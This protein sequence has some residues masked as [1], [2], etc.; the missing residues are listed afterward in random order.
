MNGAVNQ[1][2]VLDGLSDCSGSVVIEDEINTDGIAVQTRSRKS[3]HQQ[4]KT[5]WTF[6]FTDELL[7]QKIDSV[8]YVEPSGTRRDE[9]RLG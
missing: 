5:E 2:I 1:S 4:N 7:F 8:M 3:L 9:V 6:D